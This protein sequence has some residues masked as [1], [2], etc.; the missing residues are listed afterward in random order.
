MNEEAIRVSIILQ[1]LIYV[2]VLHD[3]CV[4]INQNLTERW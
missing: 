1:I 3:I 2:S 4:S